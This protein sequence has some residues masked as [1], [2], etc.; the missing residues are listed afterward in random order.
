MRSKQTHL[1]FF[2]PKRRGEKGF[3]D[4]EVTRSGQSIGLLHECSSNTWKS[5]FHPLVPTGL[6]KSWFCA[7]LHLRA[8]YILVSFDEYHPDKRYT[9]LP[10]PAAECNPAVQ[11]CNTQRGQRSEK[12]RSK[13]P[14]LLLGW[15]I[16]TADYLV[17]V[18]VTP[19]NVTGFHL[20][21][22]RQSEG[23]QSWPITKWKFFFF[24]TK[25]TSFAYDSAAC[26][27]TSNQGD[28]IL[29]IL[30]HKQQQKSV[31]KSFL[32]IAWIILPGNVSDSQT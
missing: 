1:L 25:C 19:V 20:A 27:I 12:L 23:I 9:W 29:H 28:D 3:Y 24:R 26:K 32:V 2:V 4:N 13:D 5:T 6:C 15:K 31:F 17:K 10:F 30:N 22:K 11:Q 8:N 18:Q 16:K 7:G 14:K 21:H